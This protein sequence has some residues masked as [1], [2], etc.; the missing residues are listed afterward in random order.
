MIVIYEQAIMDYLR[1][2]IP[3][4]K[5]IINTDSYENLLVEKSVIEYPS[6]IYSRSTHNWT[7]LKAMTGTSDTSK[8]VSFRM[9]M[10][11]TATL[12][13]KRAD[14]IFYYMN[15]IRQYMAKNPYVNIPYP[16]KECRTK[17]SLRLYEIEEG[18]DRDSAQIGEVKKGPQRWLRLK[19]QSG[20]LLED[21]STAVLTKG[22][23]VKVISRADGKMDEEIITA[24]IYEAVVRE[25]I[26]DDYTRH[27][28]LIGENLGGVSIESKPS[29]AVIEQED[30]RLVYGVSGN[31]GDPM[32]SYVNVVSVVGGMRLVFMVKLPGEQTEDVVDTGIETNDFKVPVVESNIEV[33][34]TP[35]KK[36]TRKTK[37]VSESVD[38]D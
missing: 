30:D 31:S 28:V 23:V 10:D 19:W 37:V 14:E 22:F 6:C 35:K 33:A 25:V 18:T 24:P 34:S 9:D 11:Y 32:P 17:V 26:V 12:Y 5:G 3:D 7:A 2:I 16:S 13:F 29:G 27:V 20:L 21:Y 1:N 36:S 8:S 4:I 38:G 15:V